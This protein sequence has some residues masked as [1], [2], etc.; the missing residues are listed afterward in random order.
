MNKETVYKELTA[1]MANSKVYIDE[2]MSKHT[3]FKIGGMADIFVKANCTE[4]I[5]YILNY[6]KKEKINITVIGNGSNLLVKDNGIRGITIQIDIQ[7]IEIEETKVTVGAGVKLGVLGS[8][9]QKNELTGFEF[10]AGIPGSIGGAV[11][12]NAGAYRRGI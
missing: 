11:R 1:N 10:A 7:D 6:A 5:K 2:L 3:S 12:M 4:D 9:I 8:I